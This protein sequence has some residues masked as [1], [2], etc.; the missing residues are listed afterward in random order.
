MHVT[1]GV[2]ARHE[3]EAFGEAYELPNL[4]AY[5]ETC[6]AIAQCY[7]NHRMFLL[8]GKA[9]YADVLERILYNGM[10]SGV[11]YDGER[12]FYPNPLASDGSHE[13]S[14]WFDCSCC[15]TNVC[16]FIPAVPG[17]AYAVHR[18]D[19]YV[20]LFAG[21]IAR[22]ALP[23]GEL[24]LEQVTEYPWEG[25]ILLRVISAPTD[26]PFRLRVRIPGWA[27]N[28]A[29]PGGLYTFAGN[30]PPAPTFAVGDDEPTAVTNALDDDGY[31][32]IERVWSQGDTLRLSLPMPVRRVVADERVE[33]DRGRVALQRGP[34][35]YCVEHPDNV[36]V[37]VSLVRV[38]GNASFRVGRNPQ[39]CG[40]VQTIVWC[41]PG[42]DRQN[43]AIPY[44]AWAHRGKGEMAVWLPTTPA[45]TEATA[46]PAVLPGFNADPHIA[47]FGDRAYL[48]PTTDGN[49]GWSSKSFSAWSS[50]D[51]VN[52]RNE[53]VIL[54]LPRDLAWADLYAWAPAAA[55]KDGKYYFYYTARQSVGVAI[56]DNPAGPFRDPLGRPLVARNAYDGMQAID[57]MVFID[58]DGSAYLYWGQGRCKAVKLGDDMVSYNPGAVRDI[59]PP[60]FNEGPFVHKR[61]GK[62]YLSWSEYDTRDPRYSVAYGVADSPLGPFEKAL[63][64]P[65]LKQNGAV[66]GAG[67]HSI[68]KLPGG[69]RWVIAYHRFGI[70]DGDGYHRETCLSP[71]RHNADGAILPVDVFENV[72]AT[73]L[74]RN[75][76][77]E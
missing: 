71:L 10:L 63:N 27:R 62:Y 28:E 30:A 4:T 70:P 18:R 73:M 23:E 5:N 45:N 41:N 67:H 7:F 48:Y 40:G 6:A 47:V 46:P 59:T 34:L 54:D 26:N 25:E 9:K 61:G 55:T 8:H 68:A 24:T 49:E 2:G 65:I 74:A 37:A 43:V 64:N 69:D 60:G 3:G 42:E 13:R 72:E 58:D 51:L 38:E 44:Y 14:P 32:T 16:R 21:G 50:S 20:N 1:G 75:R 76:F 36:D 52:W 77:N 56:A 33:A 31:L 53:G 35:V 17:Y 57:P 19:V 12:F 22:V 39:L 66:R 29:L 11:S 15:P